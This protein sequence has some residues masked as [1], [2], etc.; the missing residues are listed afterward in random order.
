[1]VTVTVGAILLS[2]GLPMMRNFLERNAVAGQL[3]SFISAINLARS[4]AIKRGTPVVICR[5]VDAAA[6][7]QPTCAG[8]GTGWESG[9]IVFVDRDGNSQMNSGSTAS[10]VLLRVQGTVTD[11]GGIEQNVFRK[12]VFLPTGLMRSGASQFTF[13]SQ[14]LSS[15][16]QRR[17]CVTMSGRTRLINNPVDLCTP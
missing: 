15:N 5:S 11:T 14:S 1:M 2:I 9:W 16:Q 17:V 13:N 12:L 4:E 10:D 6:S 3:N 8:S 7:N